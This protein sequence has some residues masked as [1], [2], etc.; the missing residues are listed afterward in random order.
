VSADAERLLQGAQKD[1]EARRQLSFLVASFRFLLIKM[2]DFKLETKTRNP[3]PRKR[4]W[5]LSQHPAEKEPLSQISG[6]SNKAL[7]CA[8]LYLRPQN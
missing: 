2:T 6:L 8:R 5:G 4:A 1:P 7:F 3:K